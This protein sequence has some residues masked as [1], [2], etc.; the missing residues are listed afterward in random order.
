MLRLGLA[1]ERHT[2]SSLSQAPRSPAHFLATRKSSTSTCLAL[3]DRYTPW[4]HVE[5]LGA[6]SSQAYLFSTSFTTTATTT[7]TTTTIH[8]HQHRETPAHDTEPRQLTTAVNILPRKR[9]PI[10]DCLDCRSHPHIRSAHCA[11][12]NTSWKRHF[13]YRLTGAHG[14]D[15]SR[16]VHHTSIA[17]HHERAS[18]CHA[19][20]GPS[21]PSSPSSTQVRLSPPQPTGG[22][23]QTSCPGTH[24][25]QLAHARE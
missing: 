6:R 15:S 9:K 23:S 4:L 25:T 18:G 17:R 13:G 24:D 1:P 10:V 22:Y 5:T 7:T 19:K 20:D 3:P 12:I 21:S 14:E 8:S 16:I 2:A 11:D